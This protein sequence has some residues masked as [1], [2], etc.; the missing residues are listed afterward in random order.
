M[1]KTLIYIVAVIIFFAVVAGLWIW[2]SASES[3]NAVATPVSTDTIFFYGQECPHCQDVEKFVADNK[4]ADQV[5]FDSLEVW[6]N[7]ANRDVFLQKVK[8]CGIVED[9]AGVPFLYAKGQCIMGTPDVE[10]F[11]K[12]V[13][14]IQ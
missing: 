10:A 9:K 8:E 11:F 7:N 3:K 12:Q 13:A 4:I 14:G 5:K 2:S 1:K 6:H